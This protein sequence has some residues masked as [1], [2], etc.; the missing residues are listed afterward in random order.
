MVEARSADIGSTVSVLG[1]RVMVSYAKE[2]GVDIRALFSELG[3]EPDVLDND[4]NRLPVRLA[5]RA[6]ELAAV[7][8]KDGS[9]GLHAAERATVGCFEALDYV[10]WASSTFGEVV[11]RMQRYHRV[12]ADDVAM[13][14]VRTGR[15][16]RLRR[17]FADRRHR[18]ESAFGIV[19]IRGRELCGRAFR[20]QEVR[21][22]H[23][24][25]ADVRPHRALF[26]CPVR[27]G[28]PAHELVFEADQMQ[29]PVRTAKPGLAKVLDRHLKHIIAQLP[30]GQTYLQRVDDAIARTLYQGRPSLAATAR[31][32][33]ASPRT[34]QR[35]LQEIGVTHREVVDDVRREMADR[36]LATSRM[37][38][39]EVAFLLGFEDVS[40]FRRAYRKWTGTNP[41]RGRTP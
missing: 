17:S 8:S 19:A 1:L 9:F 21:F 29:L 13:H 6:W 7:R 18:A 31:A 23:H 33:H 40:G 16:V 41:S 30:Q 39:S 11:E 22:V 15:L 34:V 38:V 5:R 4:D 25:P 26:R 3:V 24:A 35:N 37:S 10:L 12:I 14:V 20:I 2:R 36:L 27:F 28:A 32:L